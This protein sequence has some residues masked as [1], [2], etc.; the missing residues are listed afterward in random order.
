MQGRD[1]HNECTR[2]VA[3]TFLYT[4]VPKRDKM[5]L[6][7]FFCPE[8]QKPS[9]KLPLLGLFADVCRVI[10]SLALCGVQSYHFLSFVLM[11]AKLSLLELCAVCKVI[12]SWAL[13]W[14]VQSFHFSSFVLMC[15]KFLLLELRADVC[16]VFTSRASCWCAKEYNSDTAKSSPFSHSHPRPHPQSKCKSKQISK[17]NRQNM[18]GETL[19]KSVF[20]VRIYNC[21][22]SF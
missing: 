21:Q 11:C 5:W 17:Q 20:I 7:F 16:K 2:R 3:Y 9:G 4:F 13:C 14:C 18:R 19:L 15:A 12:T 6:Q 22:L 8:L 10:T 1:Y